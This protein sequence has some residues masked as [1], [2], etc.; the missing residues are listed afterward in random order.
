MRNKLISMPLLLLSMLLSAC[1]T[2]PP[3]RAKFDAYA[4]R[5]NAREA[6]QVICD[7]GPVRVANYLIIPVGQDRGGG[8]DVFREV[9]PQLKCNWFAA[10]GASRQE[11]VPMDKLLLPKYV[12]WEMLEG[13]LVEY[14][15]LQMPPE[16][17]VEIKGHSFKIVKRARVQIYGERISP[18]SRR[19]KAQ[20]ITKVLYETN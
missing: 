16:I 20:E 9:F 7:Y 13:D 6:N 8:T 19:I 4:L 15:P 14:E 10:D 18:N 1:A 2:L 17:R 12:E 5:V 11:A 3:N